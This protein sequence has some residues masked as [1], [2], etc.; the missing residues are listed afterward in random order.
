MCYLYLSTYAVSNAEL[1]IL[2]I[3]T[4]T[5]DCRDPD[6]MIRGLAVRVISGLGLEEMLEYLLPVVKLGSSDVCVCQKKRSPRGVENLRAQAG[7][8]QKPTYRQ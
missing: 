7:V 3:N 1:A 4:M 6:T 5:K 8:D 2:C